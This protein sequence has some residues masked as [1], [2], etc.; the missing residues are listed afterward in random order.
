[1]GRMGRWN[2]NKMEKEIKK[3]KEINIS[4]LYCRSEII[5]HILSESNK[6]LKGIYKVEITPITGSDLPSNSEFNI[7]VSSLI[8]KEY[9]RFN[10][11]CFPSCCGICIICKMTNLADESKI[12]DIWSCGLSIAEKIATCHRYGQMLMADIHE[13]RLDIFRENGFKLNNKFRN[14]NSGNNI[15]TLI[16]QL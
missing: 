15:T 10:I 8:H 11:R 2:R 9:V 3:L 12:K 6:I 14:P 7:K 16:K 5:E 1:M 4:T 13:T